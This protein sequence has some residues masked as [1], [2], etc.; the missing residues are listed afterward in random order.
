M[1]YQFNE[2]KRSE[3]IQIVKERRSKIITNRR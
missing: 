2:Q 3:L 1:K